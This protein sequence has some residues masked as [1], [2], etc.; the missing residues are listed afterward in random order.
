MGTPGAPRYKAQGVGAAAAG[1]RSH[2]ASRG[3]P[4]RGS[5]VS[6][7]FVG[8]A[9]SGAVAPDRR[10][11]AGGRLRPSGSAGFAGLQGR[12]SLW[13]P[14]ATGRWR[15]KAPAFPAGRLA[16]INPRRSVGVRVAFLR[17]RGVGRVWPRAGGNDTRRAGLRRPRVVRIWAARGAACLGRTRAARLQG[18]RPASIRTLGLLRSSPRTALSLA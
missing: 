7:W 8:A 10:P 18:A 3:G 12:G 11:R 15:S 5:G 9:G 14:G 2:A 6:P 4:V 1:P 16:P 13:P 17:R